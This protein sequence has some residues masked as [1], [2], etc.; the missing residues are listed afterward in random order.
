MKRRIKIVFR[1]VL[2]VGAA[3]AGYFCLREL[4]TY[5]GQLVLGY[6][7][8]GISGTQIN[9]FWAQRD[10]QTRADR[11]RDITLYSSR[12]YQTVENQEFGRTSAAMVTEVFGNMNPVFPGRLRRGSLVSRFDESGCVISR[13]LAE[14]MFSSHDAEGKILMIQGREYIVRG[15]IDV[16]GNVVMIQGSEG[17]SYSRI[18]IRYENM[19]A[20][21]AEQELYQILPGEAERTSEGDLYVLAGRVLFV[22]PL[23]WFWVFWMI[24]L[25]GWC[26]RRI[27]KTWLRGLCGALQFFAAVFGIYVLLRY[28]L[29][30][31]DDYLPPAWEDFSFWGKLW[32]GKMS[33]VKGLFAG[34]LEYRDRRAMCLLA[35]CAA[36][37][38][39][40]STVILGF[41]G[42]LFKAESAAA[43]AHRDLI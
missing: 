40:G 2:L 30:L 15:L 12:G 25:R 3:L 35:G 22:V 42:L 24:K 26:R 32:S 31:T 28:G 33:E 9:E 6:G 5:A 4:Q 19:S 39:T 36:G 20:S 18:W 27:K 8:E 29:Y 38:L 7:E 1:L 23:A 41:L 13:E 16:S 34:G 43:R 37:S 10:G 14:E 11:I 21:A 17:E